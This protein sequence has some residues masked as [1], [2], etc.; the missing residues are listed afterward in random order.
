MALKGKGVPMAPPMAPE[1][2]G[3]DGAQDKVGCR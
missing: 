2:W 3:A 1:G